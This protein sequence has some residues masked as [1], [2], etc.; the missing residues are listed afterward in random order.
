MWALRRLFENVIRHARYP[1]S[2]PVWTESDLKRVTQAGS[3]FSPRPEFR[4][5]I[6][7]G[8]DAAKRPRWVRRWAPALA[9][10]A[11]L[12]LMLPPAAFWLQHLGSEQALGELA[13]LT[14]VISPS[15]RS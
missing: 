3:R 9:A 4:L 13:D 8:I 11:V 6:A 14:H 10:M 15:E 1:A 7:Q 12:V 5:K 2:S